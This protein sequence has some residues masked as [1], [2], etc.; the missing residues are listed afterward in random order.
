MR[1]YTVVGFY[2]EADESRWA[3]VFLASSADRAEGLALE[4]HPGLAVVGVIEGAHTL[5]DTSWQVQH[6]TADEN[7]PTTCLELSMR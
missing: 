2:P 4:T 1:T 3:G 6:S 5:L 7:A